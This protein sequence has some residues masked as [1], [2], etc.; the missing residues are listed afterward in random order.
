MPKR[1]WE[2]V[3]SLNRAVLP[4]PPA[5]SNWIRILTTVKSLKSRGFCNLLLLNRDRLS[6]ER[7]ARL[8]TVAERVHFIG[9]DYGGT[10]LPLLGGGTTGLDNTAS[11]RR[12]LADCGTGGIH[13]CG[14]V[15]L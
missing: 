15:N 1:D 14:P 10:L 7:M 3:G 6:R 4:G 11:V 5:A 8:R 9:G 12:R 13:L 2:S